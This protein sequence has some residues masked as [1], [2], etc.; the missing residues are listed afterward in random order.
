[1]KKIG[2][3]GLGVTG[4]S[5]LYGILSASKLNLE[6][7][8]SPNISQIDVFENSSIGGAQYCPSSVSLEH[9]INMD[10]NAMSIANINL[11]NWLSKNSKKICEYFDEN[12][13]DHH[14]VE[15]SKKIIHEITPDNKFVYIPRIVYGLYLNNIYESIIREFTYEGVLINEI[16]SKISL[17]Q[18]DEYKT[19]ETYDYVIYCG[20]HQIDKPV[21]KEKIFYPYPAKDIYKKMNSILDA[22]KLNKSKDTIDVGILGTSLSGIDAIFSI[23]S[24]LKK[25]EVEER[26]FEKLNLAWTSRSLIFPNA[27]LTDLA[28]NSLDGNLLMERCR[29]QCKILKNKMNIGEISAN[30]YEKMM[31][32]IHIEI[33]NEYRNEF[34]SKYQISL[35][36]LSFEEVYNP[37]ELVC[38]NSDEFMEKT[39]LS[40]DR[41]SNP[42]DLDFFLS[43]SAFRMSSKYGLYIFNK[44]SKVGL[45]KDYRTAFVAN[46]TPVP[47][48]T[49]KRLIEVFEN[50]KI[51]LEIKQPTN[52]N[53][54]SLDLLI[55]SSTSI[56]RVGEQTGVLKELLDHKMISLS[57]TSVHPRLL[58]PANNKVVTSFAFGSFKE[59]EN[60]GII[61]FQDLQTEIDT[62]KKK[63]I[64]WFRTDKS[65]IMEKKYQLEIEE[66]CIKEL[67]KSSFIPSSISRL[68]ILSY[69]AKL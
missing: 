13:K 29:E 58:T 36:N 56:K 47:I 9:F 52:L 16:E 20:G 31:L 27:R 48:A 44:L 5:A 63:K 35:R 6:K 42:N 57:G 1:V 38:K 65:A 49:L 19:P 23:D 2:I 43:Q 68:G 30:D 10:I 28:E 18:K 25:K 51:F 21:N 12:Y 26:L 50:K 60:A 62:E 45:G 66:F 37:T 67:P 41:A 46:A 14:L 69:E 24:W 8:R 61:C 15:Y 32:G 64:S 40:I 55:D 33:I 59:G 53:H 54:D 34:S 17:I 4:I 39:K 11:A 22:I 7:S 3:V